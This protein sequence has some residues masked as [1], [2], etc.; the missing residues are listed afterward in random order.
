MDHSKLHVKIGEAEFVAEGPEGVVQLQ[1]DA[2]IRLVEMMGAAASAPAPLTKGVEDKAN[3]VGNDLED[4]DAALRRRVFDERDGVVSLLALPSGDQRTA[5]TI[6]LCLYGFSA[7]AGQETV[8]TVT[9][10]KGIKKSGINVP[11]LDRVLGPY[12]DGY[13]TKSGTRRG[14]KYGL[15]NRG[16]TKARELMKNLIE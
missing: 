8:T 13:I 15:T 11:R 3:E 14:T 4:D 7:V 6:L 2:W 16:I 10:A 9:L 1:Y 12:A 5:D